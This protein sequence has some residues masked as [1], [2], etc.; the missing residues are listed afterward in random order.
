[1][2]RLDG[3]T[4][5]VARRAATAA[6]ETDMTRFTWLPR[7]VVALALVGGLALA[8]MGPRPAAAGGYSPYVWLNEWVGPS[9]CE[10]QAPGC[11]DLAMYSPHLKV[12]GEGFAVG[13]EVAIGFYF[14]GEAYSFLE[15]RVTAEIHDGYL[16]GSFG[17][18]SPL[19]LCPTKGHTIDVRVYDF[20][21]QVWSN[22]VTTKVCLDGMGIPLEADVTSDGGVLV[23]EEVV[24]PWVVAPNDVAANTLAGT[25]QVNIHAY[26][27]A[28]D[29][30]GIFN[31]LIGEC[32]AIGGQNFT[33]TDSAA[34]YSAYSNPDQPISWSVAVGS[35][36]LTGLLT[37]EWET[38]VVLCEGAGPNG[39]HDLAALPVNGNSVS[40]TL[41]ADEVL[42]CF[43]FNMVIGA[44]GGDET[45]TDNNG[46]TVDSDG[47]EISD[48]DE[49]QVYGTDPFNTDTDFDGLYDPDELWV[50][51][52]DPLSADTDGDGLVD[53]EEIYYGSDPLDPAA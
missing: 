18:G 31:Q 41:N 9:P 5:P 19:K 3:A 12:N 36:S 14:P 6:K 43:W 30:N 48:E 50:Y 51:S 35:I 4:V 25:G 8:T 10:G 47:D 39:G 34:S 45:G 53:G 44:S 42:D 13:G 26:R 17:K 52:T 20:A 1:M 21:H 27:C 46:G 37:T 22:K 15:E 2:T 33:L 40:T 7:L 16:D 24:Q 28:D 32:T 38:P 23:P 49:L 11:Q 29:Y